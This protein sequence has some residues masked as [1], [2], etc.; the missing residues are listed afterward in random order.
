MPDS[1]DRLLD[2]QENGGHVTS[3]SEVVG[4]VLGNWAQLVSGGRVGCL[5]KEDDFGKH[6][7]SIEDD[8]LSELAETEDW[9]I[10]GE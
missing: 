10:A 7:Q 9:T 4:D 8:F 3:F 2:I 1:I 5:M 6:L